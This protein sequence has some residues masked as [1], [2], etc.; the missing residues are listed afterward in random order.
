M[1]AGLSRRVGWDDSQGS[2][3]WPVSDRAPFGRDLAF[4]VEFSVDVAVSA[5]LSENTTSTENS[6]GS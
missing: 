2:P 1:S 3:P 6:T 4:D 5:L